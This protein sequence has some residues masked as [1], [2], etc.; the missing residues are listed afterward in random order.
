MKC[1][2]EPSEEG[3]EQNV[4]DECHDGDVHIGGIDVIPWREEVVGVVGI[5]VGGGRGGR[6]LFARPGFVTPG[7]EDEEE[8][9]ENVGG[10]DVEVVF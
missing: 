4:C 2:S 9:A 5:G 6:A 1:P 3:G 8:F 7:E 10:G